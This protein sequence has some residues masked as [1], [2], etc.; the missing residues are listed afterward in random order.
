[1]IPLCD[2]LVP[3]YV[4]AQ[5]SQVVYLLL[6]HCLLPSMCNVS[7]KFSVSYFLIMYPPKCQLFDSDDFYRK[8]LLC[9]K[10]SHLSHT[11]SMAFSTFTARTIE[12]DASSHFLFILHF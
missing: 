7:F 2:T 1:M 12:L 6:R 3:P 9:L 11:M 8:F 10:L 4:F 5:T